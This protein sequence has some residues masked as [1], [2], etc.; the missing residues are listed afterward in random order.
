[1]TTTVIFA[2]I[3]IIG[4]QASIWITLVLINL[5]G[6]KWININILK[7]WESLLTVFV[8]GIVYTLGI[9]V[10]RTSDSIFH[11]FDK[12]LRKKFISNKHLSVSEMRLR[13]MLKS[14]SIAKFLEY[15]RSRLRIA[16][17][18]S[19]NFFFI[20]ITSVIFLVKQSEVNG[21]NIFSIVLLVASGGIVLMT[22][23]GFIW[24]RI[25]K[26]YYKRLDQAYKM[27]Y[28]KNF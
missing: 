23:L 14:E 10:D 19:L 1:M 21:N 24:V 20:T 26:T 11:S 28:E 17:S 7:G 9:V 5:F 2:E 16:R 3:I 13:I 4:L 27:M 15:I 22:F 6:T 25:T 18:T 12:K 8:L